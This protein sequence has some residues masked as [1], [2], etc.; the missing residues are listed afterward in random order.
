MYVAA[1]TKISVILTC[2]I[3]VIGQISHFKMSKIVKVAVII[4]LY[5]MHCTLSV[6]VYAARSPVSSV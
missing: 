5:S 1:D 6:E 2:N 3:V 4:R